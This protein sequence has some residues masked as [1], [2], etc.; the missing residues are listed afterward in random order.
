MT[1]QVVLEDQQDLAC[2]G[3]R[4][5]QRRSSQSRPPRN[6]RV[7]LIERDV[8]VGEPDVLGAEVRSCSG[9]A[10]GSAHQLCHAVTVTRIHRFLGPWRRRGAGDRATR[11]RA[12]G[13][14]LLYDGSRVESGR[15]ADAGL[16]WRA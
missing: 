11:R 7:L 16:L 12:G 13:V 6:A 8:V 9:L 1:G 5:G 4:S 10:Q 2:V 15:K 14:S 3:D